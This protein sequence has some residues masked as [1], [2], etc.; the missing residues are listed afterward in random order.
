MLN[1]R[2]RSCSKQRTDSNIDYA[3]AAELYLNFYQ[4]TTSNASLLDL[5]FISAKTCGFQNLISLS[6]SL[7]ILTGS[8][9]KPL[10]VAALMSAGISKDARVYQKKL[11]GYGGPIEIRTINPEVIIKACYGSFNIRISSSFTV[12]RLYLHVQVSK[13]HSKTRFSGCFTL[14]LSSFYCGQSRLLN[15]NSRTSPSLQ[16]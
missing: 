12:K 9:K 15:E 6:E 5:P 4:A 13:T 16:W 8:H 2:P 10:K 7:E 11:I 1:R 14:L 3:N